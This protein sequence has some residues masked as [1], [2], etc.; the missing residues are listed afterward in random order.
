MIRPKSTSGFVYIWFDRKHKRYYIG[1][2]WGYPDD[3]YICSSRWMRK[4]YKRRPNDFKRRIISI[5]TTTRQELF[6]EEEKWLSLIKYEEIGKRY[7]NIKKDTLYHW[8]SDPQKAAEV[9]QKLKETHKKGCMTDK[10][11]A[12]L[13]SRREKHMSEESRTK[14]SKGGSISGNR[15]KEL[16]TGLFGM[17]SER[18]VEAA[19]KG[20]RRTAELG[21]LPSQQKII[22]P[23]CNKQGSVPGMIRYHFDN[24]SR[25]PGNFIAA[26]NFI[27]RATVCHGG[28]YSYNIESYVNSKHPIEIV[29]IKHNIIFYQIPSSHLC[30]KT[31]CKK[32]ELEKRSKP[33]KLQLEGKYGSSI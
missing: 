25:K 4:A 12:S 10:M 14:M 5:I 29:C 23:H 18:Q 6:E 27:D 33:R 3:G 13:I 30:G 32:C 24:C 20:G 17:S 22:C 21:K 2:H 9:I 8:S 16:G 7:Y 31:G 19:S 1:S 26:Q 28:L 15:N 11:R